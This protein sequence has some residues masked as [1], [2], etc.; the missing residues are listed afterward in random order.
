[1]GS[2]WLQAAYAQ[3]AGPYSTARPGLPQGYGQS[4]QRPSSPVGPPMSGGGSFQH[5]SSIEAHTRPTSHMQGTMHAD[6]TYAS[7]ANTVCATGALH[8]SY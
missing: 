7:M 6:T 4:M 5:T 8:T 2:V 1:M 3:Q